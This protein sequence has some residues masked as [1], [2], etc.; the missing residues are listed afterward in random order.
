MSEWLVER[1][2][3]NA[4]AHF[5]HAFPC[6]VPGFNRGGINQI[7]ACITSCRGSKLTSSWSSDSCIETIYLSTIQVTV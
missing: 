2:R 1:V 6:F 5:W 4:D 3:S 7:N